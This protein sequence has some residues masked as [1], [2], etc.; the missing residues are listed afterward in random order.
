MLAWVINHGLSDREIGYAV[1][2]LAE[3]GTIEQM[4]GFVTAL[5]AEI[6]H[7]STQR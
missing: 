2:R 3:V 5:R 1:R 4:I 6:R 7:A